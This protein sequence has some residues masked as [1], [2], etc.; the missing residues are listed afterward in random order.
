MTRFSLQSKFI[1]YTTN[2]AA[3]GT[4]TDPTID[5]ATVATTDITTDTATVA[6][7]DTAKV[8]T[9]YSNLLLYFIL[10]A[11][12]ND[13]SNLWQGRCSS[14]RDSGTDTDRGQ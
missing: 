7:T 4:T 8:A 12:S 10:S 5:T 1:S 2:D 14:H 9:S 6:T 11:E 13:K 3:S